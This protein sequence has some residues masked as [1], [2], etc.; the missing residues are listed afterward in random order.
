MNKITSIDDINALIAAGVEESTT[1]EYKSDIN[2]TSDKWK[3]EMSKD[4][5]AMANANGGTIIYGVQ[6]AQDYYSTNYADKGYLFLMVDINDPERPLIKVR[7]W[8]PE[9]D[10]N[11]GLYGPGDF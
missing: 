8:Q 5:S 9:K 7:T 11:F 4:V 3:G 2:T 10:P 6:I 1:L